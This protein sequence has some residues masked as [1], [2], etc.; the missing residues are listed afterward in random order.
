MTCYQP[1][2]ECV[3]LDRH[4]GR[5]SASRNHSSIPPDR[6]LSCFFEYYTPLG[7]DAIARLQNA[8]FIVNLGR[9][10]ITSAPSI[11][12][13]ESSPKKRSRRYI[14]IYNIGL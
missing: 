13:A 2:A 12:S 5:R 14:Y 4:R 7:F 8:L 9:L 6:S 10:S 1:K 3:H 11:S